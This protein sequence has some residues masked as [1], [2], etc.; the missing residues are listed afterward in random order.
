MTLKK[1]LKGVLQPRWRLCSGEKA[2]TE[3]LIH[4]SNGLKAT[5]VKRKQLLKKKR[6]G[7]GEGGGFQISW[8]SAWLLPRPA[9][10][11]RRGSSAW[12]SLSISTSSICQ[13]PIKPAPVVCCKKAHSPS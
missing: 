12:A 9:F 7:G 5:P 13:A 3:A 1:G 11:T 10:C 2:P 8:R 4:A 6:L